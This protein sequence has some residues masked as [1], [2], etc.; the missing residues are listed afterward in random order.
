MKNITIEYLPTSELLPYARN[1]RRHSVKQIGQISASILEFGFLNPVIIDKNGTIV[2]GHGRVMAAQQLAIDKLPCIRAEHLTDAQRRAYTIVDNQLALNSDWDNELL[3]IEI[4]ELR[5][6]EF[7]LDLLGFDKLPEFIPDLPDDD[8]EK[9][10]AAK[11]VLTVQ[12]DNMDDL[13]T[14]FEELNDRGYKVKI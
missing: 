8:D 13:E 3:K 10:T 6:L 12:F 11:M 5:D 14:L 7:D 1:A 2:A 9:N 4:D